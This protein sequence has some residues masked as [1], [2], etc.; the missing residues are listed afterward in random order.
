VCSSDLQ[1]TDLV[2]RILATVQHNLLF[3]AI[4]VIAV[5]FAFLGHL[6]AGLIVASAI[7]LS[8]LFTATGMVTSKL[9]ANLMSLG[10]IDFGI[11]VDGAVVMVE[12]CARKL[13]EAR[14][15]LERPLTQDERI[16]VI[17]EGSQEVRKPMLFGEIIIIIV[18]FPILALTGV[19]GKMFTPMALTVLMALVGALILSFTFV[20]SAVALFLSSSGAHGENFITR[21]TKEIYR[22]LLQR[23]L[24]YR[25]LVVA[26][27][28]VVVVVSALAASRM[29]SEF[30][31][32]LDEG[33]VAIH[34]MRVPDMSLSQA[35]DLQAIRVAF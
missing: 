2:D 12:N 13:A 20:P 25:I 31:P 19:E 30:L 32:T 21:S 23:A 14:Q 10:A 9:T 16:E 11:I 28:A 26:S 7:P 17:W 22:P 29:G 8:M 6:R 1:R 4:L 24:N 15:E 18:Y 33:D 35:L 34:T 5:L 3:G 27:A